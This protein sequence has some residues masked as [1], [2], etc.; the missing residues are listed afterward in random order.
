M[1]RRAERRLRLLQHRR[2]PRRRDHRRPTAA[3]GLDGRINVF[4]KGTDNALWVAVQAA[5]NEDSYAD[6]QS[7]AGVIG[8]ANVSPA[9]VNQEALLY[10]FTQGAGTAKA[11]W[12]QRQTWV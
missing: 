11:L 10:V 6:F 3:L 1:A 9:N 2:Q 4:V 12:L 8:P 7:L 5:E